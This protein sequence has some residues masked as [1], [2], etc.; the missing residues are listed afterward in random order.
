MQEASDNSWT[1][2]V[3]NGESVRSVCVSFCDNKIEQFAPSGWEAD[4][5]AEL[6]EGKSE[7]LSTHSV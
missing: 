1:I 4:E 3:L 2:F 5:C 7:D 6:S